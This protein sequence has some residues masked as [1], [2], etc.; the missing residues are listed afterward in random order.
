MFDAGG[1]VD[2][3]LKPQMIDYDAARAKVKKL[4]EKPSEDPTKL[5]R[6]GLKLCTLQRRRQLLCGG[7]LTSWQA[8]AEHDEARDIYNILNDQLISEL[9][10]LLDLRIR[11]SV[12]ASGSGIWGGTRG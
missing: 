3:P 9:P 10:M 7:W 12:S 11:E 6:V 1:T 4:V 5:P 8:Q 2:Q